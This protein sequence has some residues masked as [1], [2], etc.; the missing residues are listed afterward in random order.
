[1]R[2]TNCGFESDD[3]FTFCQRCGAAAPEVAPKNPTADRV[4]AC[5]KDNLFLAV[6]ILLTVSGAITLGSR[7][8]IPVITVLAATFSWLAY[9]DAKKGIVNV[10]HLRHISGT[11]YASYILN[12]VFGVLLIVCGIIMTVA[13]NMVDGVP[14]LESSE[15]SNI[16][17]GNHITA[18][19]VYLSVLIIGIMFIVVGIALLVINLLSMR[20]IH[21]F[22][23]SVYLSVK[24]G[25]TQIYNPRTAKTWLIV[26]T[27]FIGVFSLGIMAESFLNALSNG[28]IMAA[29]IVTVILIN[30]YFID[31]P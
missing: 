2:C 31:K 9:S 8:G 13:I 22:V 17:F 24:S 26:F 28:S 4:F 7:G 15:I 18:E 12:N 1:M 20:R 14:V 3:N 21:R 25:N 27:C 5:L 29:L 10:N 11:T 30:K 6:C 16:L 23:K 19:V